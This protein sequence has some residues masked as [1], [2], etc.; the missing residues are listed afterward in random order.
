MGNETVCT[1]VGSD[2]GSQYVAVLQRV[3]ASRTAGSRIGAT[4]TEGVVRDDAEAGVEKR[5]DEGSELGAAASP[6]VDD[7]RSSRCAPS[8][9]R[10]LSLR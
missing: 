4:V 3:A 8:G 7:K 5:P 10:A 9:I 1:A 2:H 6:S